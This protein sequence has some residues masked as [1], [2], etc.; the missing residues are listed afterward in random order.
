MV[1]VVRYWFSAERRTALRAVQRSALNSTAL[2]AVQ[3]RIALRGLALRA[4]KKKTWAPRR[5]VCLRVVGMI[6]GGR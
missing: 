2:R 5:E 6:P 4:A 1:Q 3:N